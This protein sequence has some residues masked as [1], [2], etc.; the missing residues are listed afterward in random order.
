MENIGE[1]IKFERKRL[2]LTQDELGEKLGVKKSSIAKYENGSIENIKRSTIEKMSKI[3][4]C[5]P[6]YLMGW[7][8]NI[9]LL[10]QSKEIF[11]DIDVLGSVPAGVPMEA[12][13]DVIGTVQIP[14]DWV[15]YGQEYRALKV[16][17]DSMYPFFLDGDVVILK[18]TPECESGQVAVVY[19]NDYEATL[20]KFI[21]NND[22]TVTLRALNPEFQS[23][24]YDPTKVSIK[25]FGVV[26][27]LERDI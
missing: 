21:K 17:G 11:V 19:V 8:D 27:K 25:I 26:V 15:K 12:I 22:G 7:T 13:E 23:K 6:A 4:N 16:H 14:S 18:I 24:T 20:K 10:P 3:F 1:R 2:E 5:S 9:S